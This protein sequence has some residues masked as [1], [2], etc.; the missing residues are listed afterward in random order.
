MPLGDR[1]DQ[2]QVGA[3]DLVLD[4][5]RLFP[6]PLDLVEVGRL[7]LGGVDL[8]PQPDGQELQVVHLP[9]EVLLVLAG[10]QRH[11]VEARQVRRQPLGRLRASGGLAIGGDRIGAEELLDDAVLVEGRVVDVFQ[12][13]LQDLPRPHFIDDAIHGCPGALK[14]FG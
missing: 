10:E 11:L 9:E 13:G 3:D 7:R 5:Q 4:G 1:D 12:L 14:P 2:P 8:V 6:K